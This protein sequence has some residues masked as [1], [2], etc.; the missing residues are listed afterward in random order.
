MRWIAFPFG[1]F[2]VSGTA[3]SVIRTLILPRGLTSRLA[4][5]ISRKAVARSFLFAAD[6]FNS[7]ESKDK[8]L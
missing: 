4:V 2:I 3:G 1:L 6:R 7:Y 8:I 5:V